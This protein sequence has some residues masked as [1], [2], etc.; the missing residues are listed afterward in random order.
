MARK[1]AKRLPSGGLRSGPCPKEQ[2]WSGVRRRQ[3]SP[4]SKAIGRVLGA[5]AAVAGARSVVM[6]SSGFGSAFEKRAEVEA[7]RC[8][9]PAFGTAPL[10]LERSG[11][12]WD[13]VRERWCSNQR[14]LASIGA[15]ALAGLAPVNVPLARRAKL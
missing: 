15:L 11:D 5:G 8:Q 4:E 13:A 7:W 1:P 9:F 6:Q 3:E 2:R 10:Y 14:R 12:S